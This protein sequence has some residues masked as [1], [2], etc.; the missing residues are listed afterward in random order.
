[1]NPDS[2][3]AIVDSLRSLPAAVP[4]TVYVQQVVIAPSTPIW[5]NVVIPLAAV[6]ITLM[7]S[8]WMEKQRIER[9]KWTRMSD[10]FLAN[11]RP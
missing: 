11:K 3:Q 4:D 1:M 2:L 7:F 9:A 10:Q 8:Y 5:V 6:C